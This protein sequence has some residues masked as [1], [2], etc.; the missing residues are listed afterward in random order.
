MS[1]TPVTR[2]SLR[3]QVADALRAAVIAGELEAGRVYSVPGLATRFEVSATPVREAL[4]DLAK[5]GLVAAVP[6]KGYRVI[7]LSDDDLDEVTHLRLLLEV[8]AVRDAAAR[9]T[10]E[11][12][13]VL[14]PLARQIEDAHAEGD[15]IGHLQADRRFHLELV[16]I[17]GNAR[18]VELVGQL[19]ALSRLYGLR[20][21]AE[22]LG[23]SMREHTEL[24]D[25]L[26][27]GKI[28]E[29]ADLTARHIRHTRAEWAG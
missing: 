27:M 21:D 24:L 13:A 22:A 23:A 9:I 28:D 19:R 3:E 17:A 14:R 7:E 26:E 2:M 29:A 12:V 25:L 16:A 15:L 10:P 8:P 11:Q 6:N 5:E 20:A 18:L 4:L 1:A